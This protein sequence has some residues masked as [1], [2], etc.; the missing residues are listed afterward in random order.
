MSQ[1]YLLYINWFFQFIFIFSFFE[2]K[3]EKYHVI[4]MWLTSIILKMLLKPMNMCNSSFSQK[5]LKKERKKKLTLGVWSGGWVENG[6]GGLVQAV[7]RQVFRVLVLFLDEKWRVYG[8]RFKLL[9][10]KVYLRWW[11]KMEEKWQFW[12]WSAG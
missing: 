10:I 3:S 4:Y 1:S 2:K 5:E 9:M 7:G 6:G 11:V 12:W 8:V